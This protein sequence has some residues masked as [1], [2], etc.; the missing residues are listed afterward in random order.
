M[1]IS[2]FLL[3]EK[4]LQLRSSFLENVRHKLDLLRQF[5]TGLEKGDPSGESSE[6]LTEKLFS[7]IHKLKGT[8]GTY[9]FNEISVAMKQFLKYI[10]PPFNEKRGP[11][12][13]E[14]QGF[15][16]EFEI[17]C[18]YFPLYEQGFEAIQRS[19]SP[20][21]PGILWIDGERNISWCD[22]MEWFCIENS[23][24]IFSAVNR[25]EISLIRDW[26]R[27][28]LVL[29]HPILSDT[30]SLD[31]SRELSR[32]HEAPVLLILK[33]SNSADPASWEAAGVR[34]WISPDSTTLELKNLLRKNLL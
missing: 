24:L 16:N 8:G 25:Q 3:R 7:E 2:A 5:M 12:T 27:P 32:K 1:E 4:T 11:T 18:R 9:G 30:D 28:S 20:T 31:F 34:D 22:E 21:I 29:L 13:E 23:F 17:F 19:A 15:R 10:R 6:K 14:I 26:F 33:R